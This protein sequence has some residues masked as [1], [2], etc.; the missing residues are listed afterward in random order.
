MWKIS[1]PTLCL[2]PQLNCNV[3][4]HFSDP[5]TESTRD[6]EYNY[7]KEGNLNVTLH[8]DKVFPKPKCTMDFE[9]I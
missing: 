2:L 5:S 7:T 4:L 3:F 1:M 9:V 8:M 6:L